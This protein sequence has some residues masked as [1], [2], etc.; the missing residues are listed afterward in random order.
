MSDQP[1][2]LAQGGR[3]G[4]IR[5]FVLNEMMRGAGWALLVVAGIA[6]FLWAVYGVSLLLPEQSKN[7]P[8]PGPFSALVAPMDRVA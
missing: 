7:M 1:N 4:A 6:L 2:Y 8:D 5:S 3:R